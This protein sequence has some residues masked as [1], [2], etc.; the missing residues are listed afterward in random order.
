[1][2]PSIRDSPAA[3]ALGTGSGDRGARFH[4]SRNVIFLGLT[5]LVTDVSSEM[6]TAVLPLY[7]MLELRMTPLQFGLIDGLY[8]GASALVRVAAGLV[9]DAGRRYKQVAVAGYAL[10]AICK[11]GLLLVGGAWAP[12][13]ALL[14]LDRLG[15]GIRTAPRDALITLSS[16]RARLGEAF[17]VH[18]AMDT[19]GAMLGPVMAFGLLAIAPRAYDAVFIVSLAFGIVGVAT[20]AVFV[21]NRGE[22]EASPPAF[23]AA[24]L[25]AVMS[26]R[27][28]RAVVAAGALLGL[29][30]ASDALI[31]LLLQSRGGVAPMF[32][33]LL[34]VATATVYFLLAMPFGRLADRVGRHRLFLG[35][36]L[37]VIGIYLILLNET[38]GTA[39]ILV[40][41]SLL[42]AYYAATDGVLAALAGTVLPRDQISGG[43]AIVSTASAVA[44]LLAA[45]LFGAIWSWRGPAEALTLA[46]AGLAATCVASAW[47]LD[48]RRPWS[49]SG[50]TS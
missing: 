12:L 26:S 15:K 5:S 44:R 3:G 24:R 27:R 21:D 36:H 22:R 42:G 48:V 46:A 37:L 35:G 23:S 33:P 16:D 19:V 28:F 32:F 11:A 43:L 18:R 14:M 50:T 41:V 2:Y 29:L 10:S 39:G 38:L 20:I 4:V 1:M 17:G 49:R 30:T 9:A 25:S 40:C 31:Y 13:A 45:T 8:Q 7:F 47:L 6:L 34:F